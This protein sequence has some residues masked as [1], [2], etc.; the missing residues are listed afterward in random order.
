MDDVR[1]MSPSLGKN[2]QI[3]LLPVFALE[4]ITF[5]EWLDRKESL[6]RAELI[7]KWYVICLI[8]TLKNEFH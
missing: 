4:L 6:F 3:S 8:T 2:T 5:V 7:G 1:G